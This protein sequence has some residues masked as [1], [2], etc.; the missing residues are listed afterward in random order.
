MTR[1]AETE[2]RRHLVKFMDHVCD[3]RT[4]LH[5]TRRNPGQVMRNDS[6]SRPADIITD[7]F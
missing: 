4:P 6:R 2:F 1:I 7:R 5:V 3:S